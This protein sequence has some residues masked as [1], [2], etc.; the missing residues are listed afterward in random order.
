MIG[1]EFF[2]DFFNLPS[3]ERSSAVG[4]SSAV[5]SREVIQQALELA[6]GQ[7]PEAN[8]LPYIDVIHAAARLGLKVVRPPDAPR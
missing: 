6:K 8:I 1:E 4:W 7:P 5:A 3:R 2:R